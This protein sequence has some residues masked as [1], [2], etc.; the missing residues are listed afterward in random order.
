MCRCHLRRTG[1]CGSPLPALLSFSSWKKAA[2]LDWRAPTQDA[3]WLSAHHLPPAAH[4]AEQHALHASVV[5][6]VRQPE[7]GLWLA[8]LHKRRRHDPCGSDER[9]GSVP[10]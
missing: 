4:L 5:V 3:R 8:L 7:A 2:T 6:L 10:S 9:E 1:A